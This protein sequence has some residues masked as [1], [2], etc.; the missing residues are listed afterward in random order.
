MTLSKEL[1]PLVP[2][3]PISTKD[4]ADETELT[5]EQAK[6]IVRKHGHSWSEFVADIGE[7]ERFSGKDVLDWLGY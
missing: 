2:G 5:A 4:D 6:R 7:K 1:F 3:M